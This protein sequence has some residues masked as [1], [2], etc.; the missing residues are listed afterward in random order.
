MGENLELYVVKWE[1][2][3]VKQDGWPSYEEYISGSKAL[4]PDVQGGIDKWTEAWIN[5]GVRFPVRTKTSCQSKW[6][7]S[8]IYLNQLSTASCHRVKPLKFSLEEFDD[9]HNIPKKLEDR[10]RMLNNEWPLGD[11]QWP[12]GGCE[13][14][15]YVEDSGGFSDRMH[16]NGIRGLT[17]PELLT[18]FSAV[19]V[20]PQIVELFAQNTCNLQCIYCNANLSSKIEQENVKFGH[21][22]QDGVKIPV[23]RV[24]EATKEYFDRFLSWLDT[25]IQNIKR[26]HLL[27]G[28]TFLQ[29][30]LMNSVLDI[31][32]R[33][34]NPQ[35]QF[36]TFS[37]C[38]VPDRIWDEYTSRIKD[39]KLRGHIEEFDLTISIDCWGPQAEYVRSGLDLEKLEKRLAWAS[40]QDWL[41]L[42]I[43]QTITAMTI[44][45]MPELIEKINQYSTKKQIGHYFQFFTSPANS[46]FQH[47]NIF[48][49]EHWSADFERIFDAM[50]DDDKYHHKDA[51]QRM[52]GLQKQLQQV[53]QTNWASVKKLQIY[54]DELDRRRGT[55]WRNLFSWLDT[56][57]QT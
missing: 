20:T 22:E 54:L 28:E 11:D 6:T 16:N 24:P 14:C 47:P 31:I 7:W 29:H 26:L 1:Y 55:N 34:P 38:N 33:K 50:I 49:Y 2:D 41:R 9:F 5:S 17:P 35:L 43:N 56:N 10:R 8:A 30:D 46:L 57:D 36:C 19:K 27:G 44:K 15:K 40:E 37:N 3:E 45:T 52:R 48:A 32:E 21:F 13:S 53:T 51:L 39:L 4:N 25:N 23:V 42:N 12:H 18:D